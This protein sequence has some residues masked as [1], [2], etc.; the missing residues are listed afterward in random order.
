[1][2]GRDEPMSSLTIDAL[3]DD[4]V[5]LTT[6]PEGMARAR[7]AVLMAFGVKAEEP[8]PVK[9]SKALYDSLI[10]IMDGIE[11]GTIKTR[12]HK[13]ADELTHAEEL[14]KAAGLA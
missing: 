8:E 6:T 12:P 2:K 3:P 7:A 11:A 9:I 10:D 4:L 14:L 5:A 13:R 1:M